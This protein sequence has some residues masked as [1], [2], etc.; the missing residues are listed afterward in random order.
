MA[1]SVGSQPFASIPSTNGTVTDVAA[2][3]RYRKEETM[4]NKN[5]LLLIS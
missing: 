4:K 2:V 5:E 3:G 1:A